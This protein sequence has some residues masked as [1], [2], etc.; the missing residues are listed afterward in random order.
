MIRNLKSKYAHTN[1]KNVFK[2]K[3]EIRTCCYFV[4]YITLVHKIL[5]KKNYD[6]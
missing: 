6:T 2:M 5:F 1:L 3:N 4:S